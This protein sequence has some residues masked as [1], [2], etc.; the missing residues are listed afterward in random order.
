MVNHVYKPMS[1]IWLKIHQELLNKPFS[2]NYVGGV[3][4]Q[5]RGVVYENANNVQQKVIKTGLCIH[6]LN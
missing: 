4:L 1:I 6:S 2:Q 5:Q 3:S